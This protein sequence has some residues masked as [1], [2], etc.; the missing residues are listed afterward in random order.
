M[1]LVSLSRV[2]DIIVNNWRNLE[3]KRINMLEVIWDGTRDLPNITITN[4]LFY[5]LKVCARLAMVRKQLNERKLLLLK[6]LVEWYLCLT[7]T[8]RHF[9]LIEKIVLFSVVNAD[10]TRYKA[11]FKNDKKIIAEHRPRSFISNGCTNKV[12]CVTLR[13]LEKL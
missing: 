12:F 4:M 9:D 10:H 6:N 11:L 1:S 7:T 5:L 8:S 13:R 2:I 3:V